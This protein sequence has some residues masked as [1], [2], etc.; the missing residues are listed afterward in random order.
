MAISAFLVLCLE[1]AD[2]VESPPKKLGTSQPNTFIDATNASMVID[3][4]MI[5]S[6]GRYR[7]TLA[8]K[9]GFSLMSN[10]GFGIRM[11]RM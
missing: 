11:V 6:R 10:S 4:P 7:P 8:Y 9:G 5:T 2:S 3:K 1:K